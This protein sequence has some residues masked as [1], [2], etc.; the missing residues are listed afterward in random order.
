M[1]ISF[2]DA[3]IHDFNCDFVAVL[4]L[5]VTVRVLIDLF[6]N[7]ELLHTLIVKLNNYEIIPIPESNND[8]NKVIFTVTIPWEIVDHIEHCE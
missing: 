1:F 6:E 5:G 8:V 4:P 2:K 3:K 7:I